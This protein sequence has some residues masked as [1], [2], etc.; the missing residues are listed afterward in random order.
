MS[1]STKGHSCGSKAYALAVVRQRGTQ[2]TCAGD[3][4]DVAG[5]ADQILH[6]SQN[7][8]LIPC[9][10][11]SRDNTQSAAGLGTTVTDPVPDFHRTGCPEHWSQEVFNGDCLHLANI[12]VYIFPPFKLWT[13]SYAHESTERLQRKIHNDLS[14]SIINQFQQP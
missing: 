14:N 4:G 12:I 11:Q 7:P 1:C 2:S 6:D 5:F 8:E 3:T 13:S 10:L 9:I